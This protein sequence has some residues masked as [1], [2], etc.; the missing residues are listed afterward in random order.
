MPTKALKPLLDRELSIAWAKSVIDIGSPLLQE[1]VNYA[2]NAFARCQGSTKGGENEDIAVLA[3]YYHIIEMTD[4]IE[5]LISQCCAIPAIPTLRSSFEALLSMEYILEPGGD[6]I[7][8]SLSWLADYI[9]KQQA[10]YERLDPSTTRGRQFLDATKA[11]KVAQNIVPPDATE[12]SEAAARLQSVL[13]R[14]QFAPIEAES[15][16]WKRKYN[17]NPQ[18]YALFGGPHNLE[19]LAKRLQRPAQYGFLYRDWSMISHAN[20]FSRLSTTS[21]KGAKVIKRLR[22][23]A[24]I[25]DLTAFALNFLLDATHEALAKFRPGEEQ[26]HSRW[27]KTEVREDFLRISQVG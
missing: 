2:T 20:D 22:D 26:S 1:L 14:P 18:W 24:N 17:R 27:S 13:S 16:R 12:P 11:D 23:P 9:H 19:R 10:A 15:K 3:L 5:A 8:R 4:G 21:A 7:T 25:R 6:Y